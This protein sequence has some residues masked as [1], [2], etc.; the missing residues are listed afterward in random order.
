[1]AQLNITLNQEEI[2][3]LLLEDQGEAFKKILQ[4]SLNKILQAESAEKLKAEPYERSAERTDSR[5]GSR[6]RDL[7]TRVGRI[8]LQVPRHR[9]VPFKTLVFENYSRSE[10]ALVAGMAEMVVNGVSTRKVSRVME[11]L[12]GTSFSKSA[13]SDVC[14]DLD[15][16]VKEFRT[17]PLEGDYPFLTV[18]ATYFKVR[19]NSR[20]ISKAFMIAYGTNAEGHREIL[21]FGVY[22]NES[23][24]TWTDFLLGLKKRGLTGLL[25]IT[26][27]AHEGILNAI[28]KVFPTVPWQ[29]C[30]FHF[31]R[32]ITDKAP[33][34]Y[35]AGLQTELQELFNCKTMAE[36]R[37]VRDRIM[38][39]YRDVAEPAVTCLDEGFESAMTVM[40]LPAWLRRFYRTSNQ[41]ERLNK[42]LKR[43][44]KVI[45]VFPNE[46]SVLRLMG[47]VLMERHDAIQGPPEVAQLSVPVKAPARASPAAAL[48]APATCA[49]WKTRGLSSLLHVIPK[50]IYT[51][52][53]T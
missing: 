2:Q 52:I 27:D 7:N 49:V 8:T 44:S 35:Q 36:A 45:G 47:S 30:Q 26:S 24:A 33:K 11:T 41:I 28:G 22:A 39:D 46:D 31:I 40:L 23:S 51:Q 3:A 14:K 1:M 37:K 43:R 20:V 10:A 16:A 19:E 13:V 6:D 5:N 18:D 15:K 32:N 38:E 25:M 42:E 12:C 9:N 50:A 21:G 17:R 48:T 34:K 4:A 53:R 29:R